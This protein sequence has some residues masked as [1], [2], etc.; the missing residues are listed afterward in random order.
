MKKTRLADILLVHPQIGHPE[1]ARQEKD[2]GKA[3]GEQAGVNAMVKPESGEI[4]GKA[5]DQ[6]KKSHFR[7]EYPAT[8][9][10]RNNLLQQGSTKYPLD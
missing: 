6:G 1:R 3:Q 8:E 10:I 4:G 7:S 5:Q 2:E 9:L